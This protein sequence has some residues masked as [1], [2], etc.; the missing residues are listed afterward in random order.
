MADEEVKPAE[1][2]T[3]EKPLET[4]QEELPLA[5]AEETPEEKPVEAA[6][7]E[8]KPEE[9]L[10]EEP[11]PDWKEKELKAKHRQL[12]EAKR[13]EA[14]LQAEIDAKNALLSKFNQGTN[15]QATVPVD[16]VERK[17]KELVAQQKYIESCNTVAQEGEKTYGEGWKGSLENLELLGGFDTATMNGVLATD[18]PAKVLFEL[19]KNPEHY[20]RIMALPLERRIIE[21]GKLA[22]QPSN[23]KPV[24]NAPAPVNPVGG[25]AAPAAATLRDDLD[26]DK[27]YQIRMAQKRAKWKANNVSR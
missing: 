22:M 13:R 17:A 25:R 24:S 20:H 3:E 1:E 16:E 11:K 7:E 27:W 10:P 8:V 12:Q 4:A 15:E 23:T 19:G 14:E 26:D 6:A 21:M 5:A 9:K 18:A 2:I